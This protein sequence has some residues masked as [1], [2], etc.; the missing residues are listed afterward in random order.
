MARIY[1]AAVD[2]GAGSGRV[3]VGGVFDG[4][5]DCGEVHRFRYPA[6][7]HDGHLRWDI[8]SL[9]DGLHTGLRAAAEAVRLRGGQLVSVGV[10]S[11]GVDYA[12]VDAGGTLLE[13]PVCYRDARTR[14]AVAQ[15][16]SR[17]P[18]Q[19]IYARTGIQCQP[20]NTLYQLWAHV[21]DG[22]PDTAAH[23][24][25][26]P[27]YCHHVLC[28]SV[29][30]E[31]TNAST[32]QLLSPSTGRWDDDLFEA[33]GLPR[34]AM[35]EVVEAG[36][37]VGL[38]RS[39][40]AARYGC[41]RLAV[42]AP[43]TH[44][45]ASAVA[46]TPLKPGWAYISSG[47]WSLVG[48]ERDTPLVTPE[49]L[50]AGFTNEAGVFGTTRLLTNVMGLWILESCRKEWAASGDTTPLPELL[51]RV[52]AL[53]EPVGRI[54]PDDLRYFAPASMTAEIR[55]ALQSDGQPAPEDPVLTTKV[56]LDSLADR[57]AD[58][59]ASVE[60]VTGQAVPGIHVVGGGSLNTYLNRAT[61]EASGRPVVAGPVEA[62]A[63][64][65]LLVQAVAMGELE[66]LAA[67]RRLL[68]V[69]TN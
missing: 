11:W 53:H 2:L 59:V 28:G 56:I 12:L 50:A 27:D 38:L 39:E 8:A 21:Q 32:T 25:M 16:L 7:Q 5:F 3:L 54:A 48:V 66:S 46:G 20:F 43:G 64:G 51:A 30:T 26:V 9:L 10:D 67:G 55:A 47:T 22:F 44:D 49:A 69:G 13:A 34:H 40:L 36:T 14:E 23:L 58:V 1:H 45:T 4:G 35:A 68:G 24:L 29:V 41:D 33:L 52:A 37:T 15:V 17:V 61:A 65:N 19:D 60:R 18:R 31:R 6:Q 57:Y 62:T 42:V 63:M